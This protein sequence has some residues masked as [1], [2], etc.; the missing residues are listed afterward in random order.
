MLWPYPPHKQRTTRCGYHAKRARFTTQR[1]CWRMH[2]T[3]N[4]TASTCTSCLAP[5]QWGPEVG[6]DTMRR[7]EDAGCMCRGAPTARRHSQ[8]T[9]VKVQHIILNSHGSVSQKSNKQRQSALA[10]WSKTCTHCHGQ[11]H[12]M[13]RR[14]MQFLHVNAPCNQPTPDTLTPVPC[15]QVGATS[16]SAVGLLPTI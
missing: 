11:T 10:V 2:H 16:R 7:R 13:I 1:C 4:K 14:G 6:Q 3:S 9:V 12:M 8:S 15:R 5:R